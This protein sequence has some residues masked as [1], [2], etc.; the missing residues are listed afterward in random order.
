MRTL[1]VLALLAFV[2]CAAGCPADEKTPTCASLGCGSAALCTR[3]GACT[4]GGERCEV[5]TPDAA[6]SP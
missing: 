2:E 3:A 5:A 1:F 4:C 6:V